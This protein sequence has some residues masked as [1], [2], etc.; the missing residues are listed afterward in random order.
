MC[1]AE[2]SVYWWQSVRSGSGGFCGSPIGSDAALSLATHFSGG[3]AGRG[4][5][6]GGLVALG[7]H[8][9]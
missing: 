5:G 1:E 2:G 9:S 8:G 6:I 3:G 7:R 4:T